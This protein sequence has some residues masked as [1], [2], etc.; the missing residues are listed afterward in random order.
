MNMATSA[1]TPTMGA[2]APSKTTGNGNKVFPD[3]SAQLPRYQGSS[4]GMSLIC[5]MY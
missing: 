2:F 4:A 1:S 5:P 3:A